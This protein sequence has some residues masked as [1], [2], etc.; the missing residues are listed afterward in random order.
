MVSCCVQKL[1]AAVHV[2]YMCTI[3][4]GLPPRFGR[5][6][7]ISNLLRVWYVYVRTTSKGTHYI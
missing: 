1:L 3:S 7:H 5:C 4:N 2:L 6:S